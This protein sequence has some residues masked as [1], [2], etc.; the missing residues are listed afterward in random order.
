V[1]GKLTFVLRWTGNADLNLEVSS[2][3]G[4][5]FKL[6]NR[7]GPDGMPLVRLSV[8]KYTDLLYPAFGLNR[9][10]VGGTIPYD[11][12]GGPQGGMELAF[13]NNHAK[14]IYSVGVLQQSG[15][16]N[17][18]TLNAFFEGKPYDLNSPVLDANGKIG[19]AS[20]RE[21]V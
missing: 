19:R 15:N 7:V 10:S 2:S 13:F 1:P 8:F 5:P 18:L 3:T 9:N 21:R 4:D 17:N 14:G 20:C 6:T 11:N 12:V 16:V